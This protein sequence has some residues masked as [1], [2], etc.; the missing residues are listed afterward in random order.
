M[1]DYLKKFATQS[2]YDAYIQAGYPKPNVSYIEDTDETIFTNYQDGEDA[3]DT[4]VTGMKI[5]DFTGT[6]F[7][8]M[9]NYIREVVI[10]E[11]VTSISNGCGGNN[12]EKVHLP[13][14]LRSVDGNSVDSNFTFRGKFTSFDFPANLSS[15]GN[16]YILHSE[17]KMERIAV[18]A[19]NATFDSREDC[20]AII[21]TATDT[22]ICGC[23]ATV[24]PS[25]V[26]TIGNAQLYSTPANC[27]LWADP[28]NITQIN[29]PAGVVKLGMGSFAWMPNLTSITIPDTVTVVDE[30]AFCHCTALPSITLP[31][32]VTTLGRGAFSDCTA[33]TSVNIPDGVPSI[34]YSTFSNCKLLTSLTIPNS[35]TSIGQ[36]AFSG[37]SGLTSVTVRAAT[38]P[39]LPSGGFNGTPSSLV[40]Y[41]PAESVD[42][43][44]AASGWSTYANQIQEISE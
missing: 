41:V 22:L 7:I 14:T 44:K 43:Y 28:Q 4:V 18:D 15:F 3:P 37:C 12:L 23:S 10:P 32:T 16:R 6:T 8:N 20:N 17:T 13:S 34:G 33:L 1:A 11:G 25:S 26:K 38:P 42:A 31:A 9:N 29:I 5:A 27:F 30:F 36:N 21:E 19:D 2:E 40:I 24:I 39:T 35:V